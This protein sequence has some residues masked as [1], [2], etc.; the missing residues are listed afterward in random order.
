MPV[1]SSTLS[2]FS[3]DAAYYQRFYRDR[4]TRVADRKSCELLAGFV[5]A[6]LDY[7]QLP[8]ERVLDLGCGTGLW[9]RE[10][11]R[12]NPG[13]VYVGVEK[14]EY[15]CRTYGWEPGSV[16]DYRAR[17]RFDLVI[18]QGV[19]QYLNDGEA[20]AA[21]LNLPR[22]APS[23]LYLEALTAEDWKRNCNRERTDGQVHLRSAAWYRKRLRLHF[24]NCGGGLFLAKGSPAVLYELETLT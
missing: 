23:A 14:S 6:Y 4:R 16:V 24:R 10:V 18:C 15:A 20:E 5:F 12:R 13:A 8:V 9:R 11:R 2:D 19:L 7:L 22:L 1:R 17:E 21:L 3:F